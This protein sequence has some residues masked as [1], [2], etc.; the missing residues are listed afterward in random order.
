MKNDDLLTIT[1]NTA[2]TAEPEEKDDKVSVGTYT[3]VK[4]IAANVE[5]IAIQVSQQVCDES[6][7]CVEA[8][9]TTLGSPSDVPLTSYEIVIHEGPVGGIGAETVNASV[10]QVFPVYIIGDSIVENSETLNFVLSKSAGQVYMEDLTNVERSIEISSA[11]TLPVSLEEDTSANTCGDNTDSTAARERDCERIFNVV[12]DAGV[13]DQLEDLSV[14][15]SINELNT[16]NIKLSD[17]DNGNYID[18]IISLKNLETGTQSDP[19]VQSYPDSN[20]KIYFNILSGGVVQNPVIKITFNED[21]VVETDEKLR[22]D[23]VK[24]TD[25]SLFGINNG[26]ISHDVL[27]DDYLDI[28]LTQSDTQELTNLASTPA[29]PFTYTWD[30]EIAADVPTIQIAITS[31]CDSNT[32][33]NIG[34]N[35]AEL[36]SGDI[37]SDFIIETGAIDIHTVGAATAIPDSPKKLPVTFIIDN[38]VEASEVVNLDVSKTG[39]G[40]NL[41]NDQGRGYISGFNNVSGEATAESL[42][43][44]STILNDDFLNLQI[45]DVTDGDVN[46][47]GTSGES[48]TNSCSTYNIAWV[49]SVDADAGDVTIPLNL[50]ALSSNVRYVA[51][52]GAVNPKDYSLWLGVSEITYTDNQLNLGSDLSANDSTTL[53]VQIEDDN[54]VEPVETLTVSLNAT[55]S[56]YVATINSNT[57][58]E[59]ILSH[60]IP[61]D[62]LLTVTV[63]GSGTSFNEA[64]DAQGVANPF[65]YVTDKPIAPNTPT[66]E[67]ALTAG[68]CT[69]SCATVNSD[70]TLSDTQTLHTNLS[71]TSIITTAKNLGLLIKPDN[72]V[73]NDELI[74]LLLSSQNSDYVQFSG[75]QDLSYTILNVDELTLAVS[76][77]IGT[78]TGFDAESGCREFELSWNQEIEGSSVPSINIALSGTFETADTLL[79]AGVVSNPQD[80]SITANGAGV[81]Q[82]LTAATTF[83]LTDNG[84]SQT[85]KQMTFKVEL[86][87]D[88]FV[89]LEESF[90]L[91]L[92]KPNNSIIG[93]ITTQNTDWSERLFNIT[94]VGEKFTHI[95]PVSAD[96]LMVTVV[97]ETDAPE[98]G[99]GDGLAVPFTY[100][101][102]LNVASNVPVIDLTVGQVVACSADATCA[103]QGAGN[104]FTLP[105]V[106]NLH[107]ANGY[108]PIVPATNDNPAK[109]SQSLGVEVLQ[110]NI[111]EVNELIELSLSV[112]TEAQE[113]VSLP[114][115]NP[116][117]TIADSDLLDISIS[118]L[119]GA[120]TSCTNFSGEAGCREFLLQWVNELQSGSATLELK[121][122]GSNKAVFTESLDPGDLSITTDPQDYNLTA[123]NLIGTDPNINGRAITIEDTDGEDVTRSMKVSININDDIFVEP[124]EQLSVYF[125]KPTGENSIGTISDFA[126]TSN[127][128]EY[129]IPVD[130]TLTITFIGSGSS[131]AEPQ[132]DVNGVLVSDTVSKPFSYSTNAPIAANTPTI[133]LNLSNRACDTS[134]C[135]TK[136]SDNDFSVEPTTNIHIGSTPDVPGF[137][138]PIKVANLNVTVNDDEIVEAHESIKVRVR[139][140]S[141]FIEDFGNVDNT[142]TINNNDKT[143]LSFVTQSAFNGDEGNSGSADVSYSIR[144]SLAVSSNVGKLFVNLSLDSSSTADSDDV[145]VPTTLEFKGNSAISA[146]A[147]KNFNVAIIGEEIVE[148]D[149]TVIPKI[150]LHT[151]SSDYTEIDSTESKGATYT[152]TNDDYINLEVIGGTC[153][154]LSSITTCAM[155]EGDTGSTVFTFKP[156]VA[157]QTQGII[158]PTV[159]L[160][161]VNT[162]TASGSDYTFVNAV[163]LDVSVSNV[164]VTGLEKTFLTITGDKIIERNENVIL[165]ASIPPYVALNFPSGFIIRNDDYVAVSSKNYMGLNQ[166]DKLQEDGALKLEFCVPSGYTYQNQNGLSD[167]TLTVT[168]TVSGTDTDFYKK[169]T[170]LDINLLSD[171]AAVVTCDLASMSVERLISLDGKTTGECATLDL[172]TASTDLVADQNVWFELAYATSDERCEGTCLEGHTI[173]VL[174]NDLISTLDTGLNECIQSGIN[175][176]WDVR[177][178]DATYAPTG[179]YLKQDAAETDFYPDLSYTFIDADSAAVTAKPASGEACVQDNSTGLI[180]SSA[181]ESNTTTNDYTINYSGDDTAQTS[182]DCGIQNSGSK[183]WQLPT[184]QELMSIMDLNPVSKSK[185]LNEN[186]IFDFKKT[187]SNYY[188]A[189]ARYWSSDLCT[190]SA[191]NDGAWTVDFITGHFVCENISSE[192]NA[193]MH[194]YK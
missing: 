1:V 165:T 169:A 144:S 193:K 63:L 186:R 72:I 12:L 191:A 190:I 102:N 121:E 96:T 6:Q 189:N 25:S 9:D 154:E 44:T 60:T 108:T 147:I 87:N 151:G 57:A 35:C 83:E 94:G 50:P 99:D 159:S 31:N 179:N 77:I 142:Y 176:R 22:L 133:A 16:S 51:A 15:L 42:A 105:A 70:F 156:T 117:Y 14:G 177:C 146:G 20:G 26:Q 90:T 168:P 103:A 61:I 86:V 67:M 59:E 135:A 100:Y 122:T 137:F 10:D 36:V 149:E 132:Y 187:G 73:E 23:L 78:C 48:G 76:E 115:S 5:K 13:S 27:N 46:C 69:D 98:P 40:F 64:G 55:G 29:Q 163:A 89:E 116:Q 155:T 18:A 161:A 183:T 192:T 7:D 145:T 124:S 4:D 52:G 126:S 182:W 185:P 34:L 139:E 65:T 56:H 129:D 62:D 93:S 107:T 134:P 11:D 184:V 181:I 74:N 84:E 92:S 38:R 188:N 143:V 162:S 80:I 152:I 136:G 167:I 28:T 160:S 127:L 178:D 3:W 68:S 47:S 71:P 2:D 157:Y 85:Q 172:M 37:N 120:D 173:A 58:E 166:V 66:L 123:S 30:K 53:K 49:N 125:G 54:F 97:A 171:D 128:V 45:T 130:D 106:I 41:T 91:A 104:D 88:N 109:G 110:D 174:N 33:P 95:V 112:N 82:D 140:S 118:E 101:T 175:K 180:W 39:A 8:G 164:G 148:L 43:L 21:S 24:D 194:V 32:A 113:Y 79:S 150:T 19:F 17:S 114:A 170:C 138:K 153:S 81:V 119:T 158:D 141:Q 131:G 111:I 75:T